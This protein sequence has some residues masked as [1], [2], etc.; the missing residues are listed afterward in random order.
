MV[1]S[2]K[3]AARLSA[4]LARRSSCARSSSRTRWSR[5]ATGDWLRAMAFSCAASRMLAACPRPSAASASLRDIAVTTSGESGVSRSEEVSV[6]SEVVG[7]DAHLVGVL[8]AGDDGLRR[9]TEALSEALLIDVEAD[10]ASAEGAGAERG[11]DAGDDVA[12]AV[13]GDE[14]LDLP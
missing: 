8:A 9:L 4:A 14:P 2:G 13:P 7:L 3:I 5:S 1:V 6:A 11:G 10:V 12:L